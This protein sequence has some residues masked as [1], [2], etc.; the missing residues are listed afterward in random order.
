MVT[1]SLGPPSRL[2]MGLCWM[3]ESRLDARKIGEGGEE[4]RHSRLCIWC[5]KQHTYPDTIAGAERD[6]AK[7]AGGTGIGY[8]RLPLITILG[9]SGEQGMRA[10]DTMFIGLLL[11]WAYVMPDK[12]GEE[13]TAKRAMT[14]LVLALDGVPSHATW[15]GYWAPGETSKLPNVHLRWCSTTK[16]RGHEA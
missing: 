8:A 10:N 6:A 1:K 5:T 13:Y 11:L 4:G 15:S 12:L 16:G 3:G 7:G 2:A 14:R 9:P